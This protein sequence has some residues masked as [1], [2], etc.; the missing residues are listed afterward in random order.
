MKITIRETGKKALIEEEELS[1]KSLVYNV[2]VLPEDVMDDDS[3][4]IR[5]YTTDLHHATKIFDAIESAL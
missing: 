1:D 5:L 3:Q 2:V 4:G